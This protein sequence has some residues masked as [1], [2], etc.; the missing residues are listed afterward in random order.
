MVGTG[1][2]IQSGST[3]LVLQDQ[4]GS[5]SLTD[6]RTPSKSL[7]S[8]VFGDGTEGDLVISSL[9]TAARELHFNNLTIKTGGTFKPNGYRL[10]VRGTLTIETGGSIND[11]GLNASGVTGGTALGGRNFLDGRSGAGAAGRSTTGAGTAGSSPVALRSPRNASGLFPNG[12]KGGDTSTN[13]GGA[14]GTTSGNAGS[15]WGSSW[16]LCIYAP[17]VGFTGGAGGGSGG[18]NLTGGPATS[19]AGGSGAGIV[20]IA[21]ANVVNQ[22]VI[23]CDGG[24]G[25]NATSSGGSAGGGGGGGGGYVCL[26]TNTPAKDCGTIQCLGGAG[27]NGA[28]AGGTNGSTG[29]AGYPLVC[30][31]GEPV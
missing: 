2:L 19:G 9:Y 21:A 4:G 29:V 7:A 31:H 30:S 18:C 12:G 13:L 6:I 28:G 8:F 26:V 14:G 10:F 11:N 27:G 15:M 22:G 24:A 20:W 23:S 17:N 25:A 5:R 1:G 3:G 16:M